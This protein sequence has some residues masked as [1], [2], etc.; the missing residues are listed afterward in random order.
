MF[1]QEVL[2]MSVDLE[3]ALMIET[4]P[5]EGQW[6]EEPLNMVMLLMLQQGS[7]GQLFQGESNNI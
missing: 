2:E 1:K 7:E 3:T 6:L 5:A 4:R